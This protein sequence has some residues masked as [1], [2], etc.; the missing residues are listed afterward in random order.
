MENAAVERDWQI[1]IVEGG[2]LSNNNNQIQKVKS[3]S[4][5]KLQLAIRLRILQV[6]IYNPQIIN[7]MII[8]LL[9]DSEILYLNLKFVS[10]YA[11]CV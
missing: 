11:F 5:L 4:C 2:N 3:H 7:L 1:T 8:F 10:I 9:L 6:Y